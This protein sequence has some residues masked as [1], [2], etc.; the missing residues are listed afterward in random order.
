MAPRPFVIFQNSSPSVSL[1]TAGDDQSIGLGCSAAE[2]TPSPRP[3]APWQPVQLVAITFFASPIPLTGF[4][5]A[6]VSAG[7]FQLLSDQASPGV[8][9]TAAANIAVRAIALRFIVISRQL[10]IARPI[11]LPRPNVNPAAARPSRS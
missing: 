7:A 10:L 1:W 9:N 8:I 4:F 5:R 2:A 3:L 11:S 6:L